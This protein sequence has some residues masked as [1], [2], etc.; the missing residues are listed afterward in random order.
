MAEHQDPTM[1]FRFIYARMFYFI[2]K[3]M[4]NVR[5]GEGKVDRNAKLINDAAPDARTIC[6]SSR[7]HKAEIS[8]TI[9]ECRFVLSCVSIMT[10]NG[11]VF[12]ETLKFETRT[13]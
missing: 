12:N 9:N 3:Y 6:T 13:N 10:R 1:P 4:K 7:R 2:N 5:D 8:T 11:F